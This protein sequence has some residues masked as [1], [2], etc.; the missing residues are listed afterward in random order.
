T[1]SPANV[2]IAAEDAEA[3]ARRIDDDAVERLRK[4]QRLQQIRLDQPY[5]RGASRRDRSPQQLH[6]AAANVGR[7]DRA[8][9]LHRRRDRRRLASGRGTGIE[10][11]R[12]WRS[13]REQRDELRGFVLHDEQTLVLQPGRAATLD[14][15][16]AGRGG[17]GRRSRRLDS[18][19]RTALTNPAAL[20]LPARLARFTASSTTAAAGTRVRW[21]NWYALRRRISTI[22]GSS[23]SIGRPAA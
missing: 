9:S 8:A 23:R 1:P 10:H 5:V 7:H 14:H 2:G 22:S 15:E 13:S 6:P 17:S 20:R 11:A 4:R 19:R 21:S 16:A 18:V 3:R 12:P